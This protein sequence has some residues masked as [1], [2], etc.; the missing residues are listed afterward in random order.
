[1]QGAAAVRKER[2]EQLALIWFGVFGLRS[3]VLF[4]P[5]SNLEY[6]FLLSEDPLVCTSRRPVRDGLR[7][8][9]GNIA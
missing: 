5:W 8:W 9:N 3:Q 2:N 6:K 1:M 4:N 7:I